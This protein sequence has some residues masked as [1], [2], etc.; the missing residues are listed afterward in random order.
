MDEDEYIDSEELKAEE[1]IQELESERKQELHD[2]LAF[3][4]SPHGKRIIRRLVEF[5]RL[6]D[7]G[8]TGNAKTYFRC[9]KRSVALWLFNEVC[10]ANPD[11]TFV[12]E[13]LLLIQKEKHDG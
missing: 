2:M 11:P 13:L 10:T 8:F 3:A 4:K 6:F 1:A 7:H 9:G 5:C 12:G